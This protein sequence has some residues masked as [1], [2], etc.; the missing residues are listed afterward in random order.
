M[1]DIANSADP[2]PKVWHPES[3]IGDTLRGKRGLVVSVANEH[4]IAF[5]CAAKPR[6]FGAELA[7]AY[8]NE[9]SERFVRPLAEQIDAA[10]ILP[11]DAEQPRQMSRCSTASAR[12]GAG[13]I[14]SFIPSLLL[15]VR[16]FTD[17]S[18]IARWPDSSKRCRC[19][20]IPLS[21]WLGSPSR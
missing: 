17:E 16:I 6:A 19:P 9:N 4:S 20:A 12:N 14:L 8:L 21:S 18:P 7:I 13:L 2:L 11:L 3:R 5:G 15:R 10:Q 1:H